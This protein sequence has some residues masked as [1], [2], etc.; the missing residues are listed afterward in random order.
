M[1]RAPTIKC[2]RG[3]WS[4][5]TLHPKSQIYLKSQA[6]FRRLCQMQEEIAKDVADANTVMTFFG[7]SVQE[8]DAHP[9]V[10]ELQERLAK[11]KYVNTILDV[12]TQITEKNAKTFDKPL[13]LLHHL[14]KIAYDA[15]KERPD[16]LPIAHPDD[17]MSPSIFDLLMDTEIM[18][19]VHREI[20]SGLPFPAALVEAAEDFLRHKHYTVTGDVTQQRMIKLDRDTTM[21]NLD[22]HDIIKS[23]FDI[24]QQSITLSNNGK[25]PYCALMMHN[26]KELGLFR[27]VTG[28]NLHFLRK[29]DGYH[30]ACKYEVW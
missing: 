11:A 17:S 1:K 12:F 25:M 22:Q 7:G 3:R 9:K 28:H 19:V 8:G 27:R 23:D 21:I 30:L 13:P 26:G 4:P 15:I 5:Y 16:A 2:K 14:R 18:R 24:P 29:T 10:K 6:E 20:S